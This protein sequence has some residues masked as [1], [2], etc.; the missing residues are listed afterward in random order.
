MDVGKTSLWQQVVRDKNGWIVVVGSVV[1]NLVRNGMTFGFGV[2]I[3]ELKV[4]Y[5]R[6]MAELGEYLEM[7][8]FLL[9]N[10]KI[11]IGDIHLIFNLKILI[12]GFC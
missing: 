3:A 5:E 12:E 4:V 8:L 9:F 1:L 6:S 7:F 2:F 10:I 11:V